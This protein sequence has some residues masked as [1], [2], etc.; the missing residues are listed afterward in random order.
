MTTRPTHSFDVFMHAEHTAAQWLDVVARH[1]AT[2]DRHH[3]YRIVRAWLHTVRDRLGVDVAVHFAAQL[4]LVWRGLFFDGWMP[5]QVPV[6]YDV[7]QFLI[8]VAQD[9]DISVPEAREAVATVTGALSELMS[10]DQIGHVLAQLPA[11][12]REILDRGAGRHHG[13]APETAPASP[14]PPP[15]APAQA[16]AIEEPLGRRVEHLERELQVVTDALTALVEAWDERP[17]SEPE[18]E[19]YATGARQAH[20]ILLTR[21]GVGAATPSRSHP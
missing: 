5:R 16:A 12:L 4:P 14:A 21:S 10:P 15:R 18:P 7:D 19:R 8:T 9:A 2:E 13:A 1:L 11:S 20:Q 3:A 6:R 17:T